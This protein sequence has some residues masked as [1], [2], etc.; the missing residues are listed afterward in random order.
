M[1]APVVVGLVLALA[2]LALLAWGLELGRRLARAT[3]ERAA[4]AAEGAALLAARDLARSERDE[5]RGERDRLRDSEAR[6]RQL[7]E[8]ADDIIYKLDVEGR[9]AYANPAALAAFGFTE[10]ELIGR[11]Y[12]E[13]VREDYRE[14]AEHFHRAPADAARDHLPGE[15]VKDRH[16]CG[17]R[18][19]VQPDPTRTVRHGRRL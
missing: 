8:S 13:T 5:M 7:V 3:R 11:H 16:R 17:V 12:A 10:A 19:N 18:V 2:A 6:Y 15:I 1:S 9:F 14:E 4:A